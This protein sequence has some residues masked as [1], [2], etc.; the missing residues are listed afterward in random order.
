M[1]GRQVTHAPAV[2]GLDPGT[3][4]T[5]SER[6]VQS[7]NQFRLRAQRSAAARPGR[8]PARIAGIGCRA[9]APTADILAIL[10]HAAQHAGPLTALAIPHFKAHEP[11]LQHAAA[12]LGLPLIVIDAAALAAAQPLCRTRSLAALRATGH[13]SVAEACA[14]AATHGRLILPRIHNAHATCAVAA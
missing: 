1:A 11:A 10:Q 14:L 13:A 2:P 7:S 6:T 3:H 9:N 5:Q 4:A 12:A 8:H